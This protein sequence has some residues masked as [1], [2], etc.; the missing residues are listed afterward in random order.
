MSFYLHD[1]DAVSP[2]DMKPPKLRGFGTPRNYYYE[3]YRRLG[4]D[5]DYILKQPNMDWV[6]SNLWIDK[7]LRGVL[8]VEQ[9]STLSSIGWAFGFLARDV[10]VQRYAW[11]IPSPKA[12]ESIAAL[13]KPIVEIGAGKGYWAWLLSGLEVKVHCYDIDPEFGYRSGNP[14]LVDLYVMW[15]EVHKGGVEKVADHPDCAL[16]LCWPTSMAVEA[17]QA[18]KGDT[19]VYV[20]EGP[21]GCT[22]SDDFFELLDEWEEINFVRLP[23]YYGIHDNLWIYKRKTNE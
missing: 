22:A 1:A 13:D 5:G 17:L 14:C 7:I 3:L 20:G 19:L 16:F 8:G 18:Y 10:L 11:A 21:G 12:L 15:R 4:L 6:T 2:E 9:I 23:Q